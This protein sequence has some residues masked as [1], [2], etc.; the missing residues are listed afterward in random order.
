MENNYYLF[1]QFILEDKSSSRNQYL[2]EV[3]RDNG[4]YTYHL[5]DGETVEITAEYAMHLLT[6]DTVIYCSDIE[7]DE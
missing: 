2:I 5:V 1:K 3:S 7:S 6:V 4:G